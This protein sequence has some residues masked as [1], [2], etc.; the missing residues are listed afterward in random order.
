MKN[1]VTKNTTAK[2]D[3]LANLY[4]KTKEERY[5]ILWY[6]EIK[7]QSHRIEQAKSELIQQDCNKIL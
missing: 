4:W 2:A 5:K 1:V 7:K 3:E 6:Q